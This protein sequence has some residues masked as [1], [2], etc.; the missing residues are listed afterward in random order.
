MCGAEG[1]D[2]PISMDLHGNFDSGPGKPC[3]GSGDILDMPDF[4]SAIEARTGKPSLE[5]G[6]MFRNAGFH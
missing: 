3:P 1:L 5:S 6:D 4:W 2:F